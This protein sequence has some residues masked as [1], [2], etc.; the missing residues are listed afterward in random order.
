[1]QNVT[2]KNIR[3]PNK[4][5]AWDKK[6]GFF[7]RIIGNAGKSRDNYV[8]RSNPRMTDFENTNACLKIQSFNVFS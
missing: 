1:M 6:I 5:G 3:D 8:T 7:I 2:N 4:F